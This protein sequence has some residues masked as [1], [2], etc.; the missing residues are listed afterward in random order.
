MSNETVFKFVSLRA[1][2]PASSGVEESS[3]PIPAPEGSTEPLEKLVSAADQKLPFR[4]R[5]RNASDAFIGQGA[6]FLYRLDSAPRTWLTDVESLVRDKTVAADEFKNR[7]DAL[8]EQLATPNDSFPEG[9]S[10][11]PLVNQVWSSYCAS[12]FASRDYGRQSRAL[13]QIIRLIYGVERASDPGFSIAELDLGARRAA[14][15]AGLTDANTKQA[16]SAHLASGIDDSPPVSG[17]PSVSTNSHVQAAEEVRELVE[18]LG[19]VRTAVKARRRR[20]VESTQRAFADEGQQ[21]REEAIE[22]RGQKTKSKTV[23]GLTHVV[24]GAASTK[25]HELAEDDIKDPAVREILRRFRLDV[26]GDALVLMSLL[27]ELIT[28]KMSEAAHHNTREA[29][30]WEKGAFVRIRRKVRQLK[31][32]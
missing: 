26:N 15:P 11:A 17:Q 14:I 4:D 12:L 25:V 29:I 28:S 9:W 8:L 19:A 13:L 6:Y 10:S 22:E 32:E 2:V 18:A 16:S 20:L 30:A 23:I 31:Q 7:A 3:M 27:N 21:L 1:P 5:L 24:R